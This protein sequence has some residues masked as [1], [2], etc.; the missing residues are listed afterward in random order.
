M[1]LK[2]IKKHKLITLSILLGIVFFVA[3]IF[4]FD[5]EKVISNFEKISVFKFIVY[6]LIANITFI[7]GVWRWSVILKA[8]SISANFSKVY[9]WRLAGWT[10]NY[11]TPSVF[12]GGEPI[13]AMFICKESGSEFKPALANVVADS[14]LNIFTE[15]ILTCLAGFFAILHFGRFLK[16]E[17]SLIISVILISLTLYFLYWRISRGKF[18][19]YPT[20]KFFKINSW[21]PKFTAE[22]KEF[23]ELFIDFFKNKKIALKKGFLLSILMYLSSLVEF[24][25][26]A[27][28]MGVNLSFW[29]I[30]LL[31]IFIV[32]GYILPI[33]AGLGSAEISLAKF[34]EIFGY[35]PSIGVAYNLLIRLKDSLLAIFGLIVLS[36]YGIGFLKPAFSLFIKFVQDNLKKLP[37]ID[38]NNKKR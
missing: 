13:R 4:S 29:Q 10:G 7:I 32:L 27:F 28:F 14:F 22:I 17:E 16:F 1:V 15:I 34:F 9:L 19:I 24:W 8:Y 30:I 33:P 5:I 25:V 11:V 2:L 12:I 26:L 23:E 6:F 31:K 35:G 3:A 38:L 21:K 20:L 18:I 36:T 37:L